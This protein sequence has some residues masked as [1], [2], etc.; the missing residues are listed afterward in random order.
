MSK[1]PVKYVIFK[2]IDLNITIKNTKI[3]KIFK[4]MSPILF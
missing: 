3:L 1:N 2:E 4:E